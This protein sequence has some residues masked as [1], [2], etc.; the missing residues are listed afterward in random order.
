M[1][2]RHRGYRDSEREESRGERPK[3][4]PG[5]PHGQD[6]LT[7]VERIQQRSLRKATNRDA[8]EVVRCGTCGRNVEDAGTIV[9][10][11]TCPHC[12]AAL[13]CCRACNNFDSAARWQCRA[14]ITQA[15][16]DKSKANTCPQFQP[17]L[18]LDVTGRR[19]TPKSNDPRA[20]FE[21]LF[22]R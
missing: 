22:K 15:V 21:S 17:R 8:N 20:Q 6:R 10:A 16:M 12:R 19:T 14:K 1:K 13:H 11:S 2:Y 3:R 9:T 7:N 4:P 18:V 5:K